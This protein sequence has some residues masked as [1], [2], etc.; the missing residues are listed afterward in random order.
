MM[1]E[2]LG[3]SISVTSIKDMGSTFTLRLLLQ[4]AEI[5]QNAKN[6]A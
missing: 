4:R 2:F 5:N 1:A 3:G 6:I